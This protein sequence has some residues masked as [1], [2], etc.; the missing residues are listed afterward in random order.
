MNA[1]VSSD[2]VSLASDL[3]RRINSFDRLAKRFKCDRPGGLIAAQEIEPSLLE[4]L[5]VAACI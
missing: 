5:Q 1:N 4:R 3:E 2:D